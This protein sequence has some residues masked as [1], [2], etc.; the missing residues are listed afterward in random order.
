MTVSDGPLPLQQLYEMILA[1]TVF[2]Y[3]KVIMRE[4][5]MVVKTISMQ[6]EDV[7]HQLQRTT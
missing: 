2:E 5:T 7:A 4:L 1:S 6:P 3:C